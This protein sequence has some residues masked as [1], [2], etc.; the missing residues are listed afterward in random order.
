MYE[1]PPY[2]LVCVVFGVSESMTLSEFLPKSLTN[3]KQYC[4]LDFK[5]NENAHYFTFVL[6]N[7]GYGVA[8]LTK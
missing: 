3:K 7:A 5:S 1:F 2:I 8:N 4:A 6:P